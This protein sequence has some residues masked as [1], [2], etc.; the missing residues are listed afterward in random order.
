MD[1]QVLADE[2]ILDILKKD[3]QKGIV[4]LMEKYTGLIWHVVSLYVENPEDIKEC[5]NDTFSKFYFQR[6]RFDPDRAS[7]SVYLS[8]IARKLAISRYR[9]ERI[10]RMEPLGEEMVKEDQSLSG[11]ELRVDMERAMAMLKPN[12]LQIIRMRYYDG[13]TVREI[14]ESLKIPYETAKKRHQRSILKL[15]QSLLLLLVLLLSFSVCVYGFLHY[16]QVIS[17]VWTGEGQVEPEEIPNDDDG[18]VE[19]I[20]IRN[21][22]GRMMPDQEKEYGRQD[23]KEELLRKIPD[24]RAAK[25]SP[26][27]SETSD[28]QGVSD[29][30][31]GTVSPGY[32]IS[33]NPGQPVYSLADKVYYEGEEYTLILEEAVYLNNKV[34]VTAVLR[35]KMM[36][37][38]E[39]GTAA[40]VPGS[41]S[42]QLGYGGSTWKNKETITRELDEY[43]QCLTICFEDVVLPASEQGLKALT[44]AAQE[45]V[46]FAFDMRPVEQKTLDQEFAIS[47]NLEENTWE[48]QEYPVP[49]GSVYIKE[50]TP[51]TVGS[52][53]DIPNDG[54]RS[55]PSADSE[56]KRWRLQIGFRSKDPVYS[57]AGFYGA[58]CYIGNEQEQALSGPGIRMTLDSVSLED[59]VTE[60]TLET[61]ADIKEL[62]DVCIRFHKDDII[63]YR[64]NSQFEIPFSAE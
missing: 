51:L 30:E 49:G 24:S 47:L 63:V 60:Y 22:Q 17:S 58:H 54:D 59:R 16:F 37:L 12:E 34:T 8:A 14:A 33:R 9:K 50:C 40:M 31:G 27:E 23:E 36:M 1:V 57:A 20:I 38:A 2:K 25:A 61:D 56:K 13:M 26:K 6:K 3:S 32:G 5:I 52:R 46:S 4:L 18:G 35:M 62:E 55:D 64:W 45:S 7:L 43:T 11:A 42:F 29:M 41:G 10:R 28:G 44:M 19:G 48:E 39:D 15:G 21:E 53:E